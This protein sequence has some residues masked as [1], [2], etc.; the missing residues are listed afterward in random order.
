MHTFLFKYEIETGSIYFCCW[1]KMLLIEYNCNEYLCPKFSII[2]LWNYTI[3]LKSRSH[4]FFLHWHIVEFFPWNILHPHLVFFFVDYVWLVLKNLFIFSSLLCLNLLRADSVIGGGSVILIGFMK[5]IPMHTKWPQS[6]PLVVLNSLSII[7]I[8]R[9][10]VSYLKFS[11]SVS[12]AIWVKIQP[13][14]QTTC[15]FIAYKWENKTKINDY[16]SILLKWKVLR[17][18]K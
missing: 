12:S 2:Y 10:S 13:I 4:R 7:G 5:I 11:N 1:Q 14:M 6:S 18:S 8:Q 16:V 3:F 17:V 9:K 15:V